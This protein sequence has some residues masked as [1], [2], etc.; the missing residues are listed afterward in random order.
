MAT[1]K[2]QDLRAAL[3]S[4]INSRLTSQGVTGVTVTQFPPLGDVA[5]EDRIYLGRIRVDQEPLTMGGT[6]RL[7]DEDIEVDL[8]IEAVKPGGDVTDMSEMEQRAEVMLGVVENALR[9]DS[10]V[11]STVLFGELASFELIPVT[12]DGRVGVTIEAVISAMS[13]I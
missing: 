8:F 1:S 13:N 4:A 12:G 7:V 10:D 6:A 2:F 11:G 3:V 5:F 9:A